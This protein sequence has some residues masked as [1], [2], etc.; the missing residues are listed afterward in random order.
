MKSKAYNDFEIWVLFTPFFT[1]ALASLLFALSHSVVFTVTMSI[2]ILVCI[3]S[4]KQVIDIQLNQKR[5]RRKVEEEYERVQRE[6]DEQMERMYARHRVEAAR[7]RYKREKEA[8]EKYEEWRKAKRESKKETNT[9]TPNPRPKIRVSA[10][11]VL[12]IQ[13]GATQ[14]EIKS[15]YKRMALKYHPDKNKSPDAEIKM[16]MVNDARQILLGA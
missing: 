12:E 13:R 6:L 4:I 16:K 5:I 1:L 15:A 7:Q 8:Q 14:E 11:E 2:S 9:E 10:Y 3:L